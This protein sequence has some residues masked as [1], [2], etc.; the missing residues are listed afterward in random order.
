M[1]ACHV[2]YQRPSLKQDRAWLEFLRQLFGK[3]F[4]TKE[5]SK[6]LSNYRYRMRN[7]KSFGQHQ[8]DR[9]GFHYLRHP[10][11]LISSRFTHSGGQSSKL[12]VFLRRRRCLDLIMARS[13]DHK[14][15]PLNRQGYTY[16][17]PPGTS[18]QRSHL[19]T[20]IQSYAERFKL[21]LR[22]SFSV[23]MN[24]IMRRGNEVVS[25]PVQ[26]PFPILR[27]PPE[28]RSQIWTYGVVSDYPITVKF[29]V[30]RNL[31]K[32]RQPISLHSEQNGDQRKDDMNRTRTTLAVALTSRILYHEV[33]W[34]YYSKNVFSFNFTGYILPM[35]AR[36]IGRQNAKSVRSIII[37]RDCFV[38]DPDDIRHLSGL[39]HISLF[40]GKLRRGSWPL[41]RELKNYADSQPGLVLSVNGLVWSKG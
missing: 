22:K 33:T 2:L 32:I 34:I 11:Y 37:T 15:S 41:I 40:G 16:S 3:S 21:Y 26:K 27:L 9:L 31:A 25:T 29:P 20:K 23:L 28:I 1:D 18:S 19:L 12:L 5:S 14:Y 36:G 13:S 17:D 35:F 24:T 39:R 8:G 4:I 6:S 10:Q 30:H 7:A 38:V